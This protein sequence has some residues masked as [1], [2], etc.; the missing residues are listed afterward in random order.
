MPPYSKIFMPT[1]IPITNATPDGG[2]EIGSLL[3]FC[4]QPV[5]FVPSYDRK[6]LSTQPRRRATRGGQRSPNVSITEPQGPPLNLL[7]MGN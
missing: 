5:L 7:R 1:D 3:V 2:V 4:L 6:M